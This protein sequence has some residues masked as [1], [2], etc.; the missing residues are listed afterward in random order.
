M[1]TQESRIS[2][3]GKKEEERIGERVCRVLTLA[4]GAPFA[5]EIGAVECLP[6]FPFVP[7][8]PGALLFPLYPLELIR[9]RSTASRLSSG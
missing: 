7:G 4:L 2:E 5:L 8:G 1:K 3:S 6:C 9:L